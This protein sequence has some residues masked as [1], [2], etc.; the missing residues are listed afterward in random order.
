MTLL[1]PFATSGLRKA[2][3]LLMPHLPKSSYSAIARKG[4]NQ[5][6][7]LL[8]GQ[9]LNFDFIIGLVSDEYGVHEHVSEEGFKQ[10]FR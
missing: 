7:P 9:A 5:Y 10:A 1:R 6:A 3:S 4:V 2:L 8:T